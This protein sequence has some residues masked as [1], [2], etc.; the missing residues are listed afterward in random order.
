MVPTGK[1]VLTL[2]MGL[3][4]THTRTSMVVQESIMVEGERSLPAYRQTRSSSSSS[5][6]SFSS[7]VTVVSP[8]LMV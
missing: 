3:F 6:S 2:L 8:G 4:L 7:E 5:S 1:H